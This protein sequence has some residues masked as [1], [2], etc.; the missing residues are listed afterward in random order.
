MDGNPLIAIC[1]EGRALKIYETLQRKDVPLITG[2]QVLER[3]RFHFPR[4][5]KK[6]GLDLHRLLKVLE[7]ICWGLEVYPEEFYKAH[8]EDADQIIGQ[9]DRKDIH[10]LALTLKLRRPIWTN[11]LDFQIPEVTNRVQVY[12]TLDLARLLNLN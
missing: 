9:R 12:T 5:A 3:V 6:K 10:P 4:I 8:L 1:L 11:D 7:L 2:E